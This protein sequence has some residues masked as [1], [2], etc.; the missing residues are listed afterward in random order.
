MCTVKAEET[1]GFLGDLKCGCWRTTMIAGTGNAKDSVNATKRM[2]IE[3]GI[4]KPIVQGFTS[5]QRHIAK[6]VK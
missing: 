6:L 3:K 1:L 5:K 4:N 2:M